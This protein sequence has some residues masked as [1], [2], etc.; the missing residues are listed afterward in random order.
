[1]DRVARGVEVAQNEGR[2]VNQFVRSFG[3][4]TDP[5]PTILDRIRPDIDNK[6]AQRPVFQSDIKLFVGAVEAELL[7]LLVGDRSFGKQQCLGAGAA[8]AVTGKRS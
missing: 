8:D 4:N 3:E 1:M 6:D 5:S 7:M 2:L